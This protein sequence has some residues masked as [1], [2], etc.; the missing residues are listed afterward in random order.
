VD[1]VCDV[2]ELSRT[3]GGE[4]FDVVVTTEMLEHVR[5]WRVAVRNLKAAVAPRG[6]LLLTTRSLG[7]PYHDFPGDY[8]RYE[9]DDMRW[10]FRDFEDVRVAADPQHP[11]VFVRARKPAAFAE[12]DLSGREL[13]SVVKGGPAPPG[14]F[15]DHEAR[16]YGERVMRIGE[17]GTAVAR[18]LIGLDLAD[19]GQR[20]FRTLWRSVAELAEV[21][22]RATPPPV[23][24]SAGRLGERLRRQ[25]LE[26]LTSLRLLRGGAFGAARRAMLASAAGSTGVNVLRVAWGVLPEPAFA[27]VAARVDAIGALCAKI[28]GY[29]RPVAT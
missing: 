19:V 8:W 2:S 25:L 23:P 29:A 15:T 9:P 6:L 28:Q 3:F 14:A 11:G 1:R 4:P 5:D 12:A 20:D 27:E 16:L 18:A 7:F 10:I 17:A 24:P 26:R 13:F 21:V 22:E